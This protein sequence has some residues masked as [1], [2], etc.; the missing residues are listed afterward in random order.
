LLLLLAFAVVMLATAGTA[1]A[2]DGGGF[3]VGLLSDVMLGDDGG[4]T[5]QGAGDMDGGPT[6]P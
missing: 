5:T 6:N 2:V 3:D 1:A 4:V